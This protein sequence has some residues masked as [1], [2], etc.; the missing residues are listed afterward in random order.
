VMPYFAKKPVPQAF[1]CLSSRSDLIWALPLFRLPHLQHPKH[2][3]KTPHPTHVRLSSSSR[4]TGNRVISASRL[5]GVQRQNRQKM[6]TM[7]LSIVGV[8]NQD[9]RQ[10]QVTTP[11]Q[12]GQVPVPEPILGSD[13]FRTSKSIVVFTLAR[14]SQG[15]LESLD[16]AESKYLV[17]MRL[18]LSDTRTSIKFLRSHVTCGTR[19]IR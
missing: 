5:L 19:K 17:E 10:S 7:A 4:R 3:S 6:A 11:P 13:W 14:S 2:H 12:L 1:W 16:G 8:I 18:V 9:S 15:I